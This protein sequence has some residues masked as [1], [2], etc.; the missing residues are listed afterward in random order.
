MISV[1]TTFIRVLMADSVY[2]KSGLCHVNGVLLSTGDLFVP[3]IHLLLANE[4][5]MVHRTDCAGSA[6]T[7]RSTV[8]ICSMSKLD[9]R[10]ET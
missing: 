7:A 6:V 10:G 1:G 5:L 8:V 9:W 2:R 3:V 4:R